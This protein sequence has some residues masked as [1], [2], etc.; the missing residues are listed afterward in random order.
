MNYSVYC[1]S[2]PGSNV[3]QYIRS[4]GVLPRKKLRD[5]ICSARFK[6]RHD[7][8]ISKLNQWILDLLDQG[9]EPEL[10]VL[11]TGEDRERVE[12]QELQLVDA[13][14]PDLLNDPLTR[15]LYPGRQLGAKDTPTAVANRRAALKQVDEQRRKA[16]GQ[17]V[18][19]FY[20]TGE[21]VNER[22][23]LGY[24]H[25][26]LPRASP[27]NKEHWLLLYRERRPHKGREQQAAMMVERHHQ[28]RVAWGYPHPE[29]TTD[30]PLNRPYRDYL[31]REG[32]K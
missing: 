20:R 24:P 13:W 19:L 3:I 29:Y 28:R 30:H 15:R 22:R 6:Q 4:T 27:P 32:L 16:I 5:H 23:R 10:T 7:L 9:L 21:R 17:G 12:E 31:H 26:E 25:P 2:A 11:M 18:S 8:P 14:L 1:L